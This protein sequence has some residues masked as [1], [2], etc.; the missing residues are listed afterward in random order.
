MSPAEGREDNGAWA[1]E[2]SR[3]PAGVAVFSM[4]MTSKDNV[5]LN[6]EKGNDHVY[7]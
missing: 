5:N 1:S 3:A 2:R 6:N 4:N 7:R